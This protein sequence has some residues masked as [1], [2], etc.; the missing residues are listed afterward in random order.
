VQPILRH[1]IRALAVEPSASLSDGQLLELYR[2]R[3][4]ERAFASLVAR[5]GPLVMGVCRRA[6]AQEQDAEDAFQATFLVL[7]RRA[8]SIREG[9]SLASWLHRVAARLACQAR[10]AAGRRT[11][12]ERETARP[13]SSDA[14]PGEEELLGLDEELQQL[15]EALR[16]PLLLCY[17]AGLTQQQA[18]HQLGWSFGTLRRRL[19]E[20]RDRLRQRLIRRGVAPAALLAATPAARASAVPAAL[21]ATTVRAALGGPVSVTV[22]TL[23]EKGLSIMF[24]TRTKLVIALTLAVGLAA[25]FVGRESLTAQQPATERRAD[26]LS[27]YSKSYDELRSER[28]TP[29]VDRRLA[30]L[31]KRLE[32]ALGDVKALRQALKAPRADATVLPLK[33]MPAARAAEVVRAAYPGGQ[34]RIDTDE[35]TNA[36]LVQASAADTQ[37]IRRLLEALDVKREG[38][39]PKPLT[40]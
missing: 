2:V 19:E 23:T 13:V 30:E 12:H 37:A 33:F 24:L 18:A 40:R 6:L 9:S 21:A 28:A 27:R 1:L 8:D 35:R 32:D 4:D 3:R 26:P 31:E 17:L 10:R 7:A 14:P 22:L 5:H 15:P 25:G 20:A 38:E 36:L 29:D 39:A 16:A 11:R 34:V